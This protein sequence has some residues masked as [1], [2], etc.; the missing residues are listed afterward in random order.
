[1]PKQFYKERLQVFADADLLVLVPIKENWGNTVQE[2]TAAGVPVL[3][4]YTCGACEIIEGQ[5][6]LVVEGNVPGIRDGIKSLLTNASL[7]EGFGANLPT[8][9]A[10]ISWDE[11]VKQMEDLFESWL[12]E[13]MTCCTHTGAIS[14]P[15]YSDAHSIF[16]EILV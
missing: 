16:N 1:M 4:I 10:K 7:F 15:K 5:A 3:F 2:A 12:T 13:Q 8:L 11:S 14:S 6:G 9:V